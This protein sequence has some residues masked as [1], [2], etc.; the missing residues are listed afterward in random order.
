[1]SQES[2]QVSLADLQRWFSAERMSTYVQSAQSTDCNPVDLYI[3][4]GRLSKALLEDIAHVEVLLRNFISER[5]AKESSR[6]DWYN[7]D[8][9]FHFNSSRGNRFEN[10]IIEI[11]RQIVRSGNTVTPGRVIAD[12]SLG[13]WCFLLSGRLEQT[14]WKALRN[15]VNGGMPNYLLRKRATFERH[16]AM[17][18][19]LRN[20]LSHQEHIVLSD[21][22]Q[23]NQYLDDQYDNL[24]WVARSIEAKAADWIHS[25]SRV[26][27]LRGQRP[28][29][30]LRAGL[31]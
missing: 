7:D 11:E 18:R 30:R 16:V 31:Q 2:Q 10:S 17:M 23:E 6:D 25:Q 13:S 24:C 20:R 12:M 28:K 3:W 9:K 14:V 5:L 21:L 29:S 8:A 22:A 19:E 27:T 4:N 15:P 1:M 26:A